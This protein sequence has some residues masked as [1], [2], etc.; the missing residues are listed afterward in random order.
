MPVSAF[1]CTA[2]SVFSLTCTAHA[3]DNS[4]FER[5][6]DLCKSTE[7]LT[8]SITLTIGSGD[9]ISDT[10]IRGTSDAAVSERSGSIYVPSNILS[11]AFDLDGGS[12]VSLFSY[13]T[14]TDI[15]K[16]ADELGLTTELDGDIL[17]I[18]DP[19]ASGRIVIYG[20]DETMSFADGEAIRLPHGITVVD[21]GSRDA[22][23]ELCSSINGGN[24]TDKVIAAPDVRIT[25]SESDDRGYL[26]ADHLSWGAEFVVSDSFALQLLQK[27]GAANK[28][29][30]VNIAVIDSG[31]D[32]THP[33]LA[34]RVD[35]EKGYDFYSEDIVSGSDDDTK[36][37]NEDDSNQDNDPMDEHGHGT[38]VAGIICD[39]TLSNVRIIP[40]KI[41]NASGKSSVSQ[42]TAAL[43]M[44]IDSGADIINM[45]LGAYDADGSVTALLTPIFKKLE[46]LGITAVAAS[47]N[48]K[49]NAASYA[50]ANIDYCITV[51]ACDSDGNFA[52]SYS[53]YG[54]VI[55][56]CAP[57]SWIYSTVLDG[58]YGSKRG[59]S[60]A[61]PFVSAAAAML[62][63]MDPELTP[64]D[65]TD[66]LTYSA[67][68][69]GEEG[70]DKYYGWGILDIG[71]LSELYTP[72]GAPIYAAHAD[73][74]SIT[75]R[76]DLS[77]EDMPCTTAAAVYSGGILISA[78]SAKTESSGEYTLPVSLK[79]GD[80]VKLFV[81]DSVERLSPRC[82]IYT[83]NINDT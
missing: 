72:Q 27:Y 34:A 30:T 36:D 71:S 19:Y 43:N 7:N 10:G 15:F 83:I 8:E 16:Y 4:C 17:T 52:S 62:K 26:W 54:N 14:E 23:R 67:R 47:G 22:A 18:T 6:S 20:A 25:L 38:H 37:E 44:A 76:V 75:A 66:K 77:S 13:D 61:C 65:I 48:N 9:Y 35:E 42:L 81:F 80:T 5:L 49:T 12:E 11:D 51:S 21:C 56:I 41:T 2:L 24:G 60:M 3:E 55:D 50:P 79:G 45:S 32:Y 29:K 40:F 64:K 28:L 53:N 31:V 70:F 46:T 59:T 82:N 69:A 39:N 78:A 57:G 73:D 63:S 33:F 68:D 58:K 1:V 74:D